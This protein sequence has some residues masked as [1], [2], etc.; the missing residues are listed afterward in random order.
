MALSDKWLAVFLFLRRDR[1]DNSV[2]PSSISATSEMNMTYGLSSRAAQIANLY[3]FYLGRFPD[4]NSFN[5]LLGS[6]GDIDAIHRIL[7]TVDECVALNKAVERMKAKLASY[8]VE[9]KK[10][11]LFSAYGNGNLGD[12][13]M[14]RV[15]AQDL[16]ARYHV[17]CFAY[18]EIALED[19][20]FPEDRRLDA[21][22]LPLNPRLLLLF[23]GL[24][25]GGGGFLAWPHD[26]AW[27]PFWAHLIPIPYVIWAIGAGNPPDH[28]IHNLISRSFLAS[29]RDSASVSGL[30]VVKAGVEFCPDPI[31]SLVTPPQRQKRD[32]MGKR[33][34]VLRG[35]RTGW[36]DKVKE[37]LRERD[38]VVLFDAISDAELRE[39]FPRA[40]MARSIESFVDMVAEVDVVISERFHGAILSLLCGCPTLGTYRGDHNTSKLVSLFAMLGIEGYCSSDPQID[41]DLHDYPLSQVATHIAALKQTYKE[42]TSSLMERLLA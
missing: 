25:I 10:I 26:R 22:Y 21:S 12:F 20:P 6:G 8:P 16:E 38:D 36:H 33:L 18:S 2:W 28:R 40:K 11:L 1:V 37:M 35:A 7:Q 39:M 24:I 34:F 3:S 4:A 31:L 30:A 27:D 29:G 13:E 42:E 41:D 19:Y 32:K 9:K 5:I 15:I 23:D 17:V 14:A